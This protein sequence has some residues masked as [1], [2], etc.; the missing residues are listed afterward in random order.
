[1]PSNRLTSNNLLRRTKILR[2]SFTT[3]YISFGSFKMK[4]NNRTV[5]NIIAQK[6][7]K[8]TTINKNF[9]NI[10]A[11]LDLTLNF[12][13]YI[14]LLLSIIVSLLPYESEYSCT[15]ARNDPKSV[16]HKSIYALASYE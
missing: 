10:P 11:E 4:K 16:K 6:Q 15:K 9:Q 8:Q 1:M 7:L 5:N 3:A 2:R 13:R 14:K 12:G